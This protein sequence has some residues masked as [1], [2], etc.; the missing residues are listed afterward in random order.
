MSFPA[1]PLAA[2]V[3]PDPYPYYAALAAEPM[4]RHEAL[5]LFVAARPR[6]VED[7]LS[8]PLV[9]VRP[10]AEPVPRAIAGGTAGAVF[11]R[12]VRMN[13]GDAHA[14]GKRAVRAALASVAPDA[15]R[16]AARAHAARLAEALEVRLR[17]ERAMEVA[18]DAPVRTLADL[19]GLRP[20]DD[21]PALTRA[22]AR[23]FAAAAS[24]EEAAV[25]AGA[26][27]RLG[28][29]L[30]GAGLHAA[31]AD[32]TDAEWAAANAL[33]LLTQTLEA[34]AGLVGNALV[35]LGRDGTLSAAPADA[36]VRRVLER[37]PPV[38]NTRRFV[39]ERG[40]VADVA[41]APGDPILVVLAAAARP[42]GA[43]RHACPGD[44]LAGAL[45]AGCLE[46]LLAAGPDLAAFASPVR[47]RPAPNVR[48]PEFGARGRA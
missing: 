42:F 22:L 43:G 16:S 3:H 36:L 14:D 48:I 17:P 24:V 39:A 33:G 6:D 46:A 40:V 13:D 15:A 10:P 9:R 37:D 23:G 29:A 25:G 12:L 47:Y 32:G 5:G 2:V 41:V 30:A 20:A 1:D 45:A 27:H 44:A 8:S 38:H 28:A 19:V 11:G 34:T 21:A 18:W 35:A 31:L 7:V 26:A 4:R